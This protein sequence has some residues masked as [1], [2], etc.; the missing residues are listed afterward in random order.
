MEEAEAIKH[1]LKPLA[2][3]APIKELFAGNR[4]SQI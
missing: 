1:F 2:F 4:V 3:I